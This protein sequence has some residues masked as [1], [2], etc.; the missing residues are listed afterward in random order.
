[1][2][3]VGIFQKQGVFGLGGMS[4][5][6]PRAEDNLGPHIGPLAHASPSTDDGRALDIAL[7]RNHGPG[8]D[9]NLLAIDDGRGVY[10]GGGVYAGGVV[11]LQSGLYI[12][13]K[14]VQNFPHIMGVPEGR[15]VFCVG[16]VKKILWTEHQ[17]SL[18]LL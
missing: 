3:C 14:A 7:G 10:G 9:V 2:G 6:G 16:K 11:A 5:Q 15:G 18:F 17:H 4:Q 13:L 8:P 1:M 12:V